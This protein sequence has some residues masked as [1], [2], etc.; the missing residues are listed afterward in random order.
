MAI[1]VTGFDTFGKLA[2]NPTEMIVTQLAAD[3]RTTVSEEFHCHV[4][5]TAY[6]KAANDINALIGE[7]RPSILLG[8]GVSTKR[9]KICLERFA[10]NLD[11]AAIEDNAGCIRRGEDIV[12]G[13]PAALKTNVD[14]VAVLNRLADAGVPAEISNHAGTFVC[15]HVYYCAL[16]RLEKELPHV[17]CL[18]VHV[19]LPD[20][21]T[22]QASSKTRLTTA[23]LLQAIHSIL[24]ELVRQRDESQVRRRQS[25]LRQV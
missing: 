23:D 3:P 22:S 13:G 11:D 19:P 8:L 12:L 4:L 6:D 20:P 9:D 17:R 16:Q 21:A 24:A 2:F 18:F 25:R 7:T 10:L 14:I 1:L 5:P 15:N